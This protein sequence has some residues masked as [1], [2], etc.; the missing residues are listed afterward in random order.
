MKLIRFINIVLFT[1]L[2]LNVF[3]KSDTTV[4]PWVTQFQFTD[5]WG[6]FKVIW[7]TSNGEAGHASLG[8]SPALPCQFKLPPSDRDLI[9]KKLSKAI[10][11]PKSAP[12]LGDESF[13]CSDETRVSIHISHKPSKNGAL[14]F[15]RRFSMMPK[16][17]NFTVDDNLF[18]AA[19]VAYRGLEKLPES[20]K[21]NPLRD[22]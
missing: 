5:G 12:S 6:K 4:G 22:K 2:S 21:I 10:K 9:I 16:C 8:H 11:N 1:I 20:C 17:N 13:I 18:S 15:V 19:T 7:V 14:G 3:A